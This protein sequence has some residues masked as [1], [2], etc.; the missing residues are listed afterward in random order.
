MITLA[1]LVTPVTEDEALASA[2]SMLDGVGFQ[3]TSWQEGSSQLNML[4]LFCKVWAALTVVIAAIAAGGFTTLATSSWLTLVARYF[5][6][7]ERVPAQY[8]IGEIVLT[9]SAG[10]PTLNFLAGDLI[11]A[12]AAAGSL[13]AHSF[14]C[15]E[16]G[17]LPP[18]S[19]I[20]ITFQ[21]DVAGIASNIPAGTALFLWTPQVGV[22]ATCPAILPSNTWI[23]T[24]GEDEEADAR[25][26]ARCLGRWSRLS[27]G[28]T[29]GAY[30][31]WAL[32][33]LN[34]LTRVSIASAEGDGT[35]TI[36]GATALGPL[37]APQ[38]T[39]IEN[40]IYGVTDGVGRRP[41]NDIVN[42]IPAVVVT[43][44]AI[45]ID[46]YVEAGAFDTIATTMAAA[47]NAYIGG[48][49]IG[50]TRLVGSQGKIIFSELVRIAQ[51]LSKVR[52]V[53][54]SIDDDV[55]LNEDEIYSP[56]ITINPVSVAPGV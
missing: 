30:R 37:S 8:A 13:T 54:F 17:S 50:G 26:T 44:P 29:D 42:V 1:Q 19:T 12:D 51:T 4:R 32:E 21:A 14:T 48:T 40:Y 36:I 20:T 38:C 28:N 15:I 53:N 22:T 10:A 56:T 5:Y 49:P 11:I 46:A 31:G 6:N 47:L 35:V 18:N 55:L 34:A 25:L 41:I 39:T 33:G 16:G 2:V 27:Y 45:T 7:L 52:S 23:T 43:T 9:S 3:A 24:P